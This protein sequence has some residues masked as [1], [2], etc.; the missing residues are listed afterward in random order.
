MANVMFWDTQS[1][2]RELKMVHLKAA[3][4]ATGAPT[5]DA[6]ASLG[7]ASIARTSAGLYR[8]TLTDKYTSLVAIHGMQLLATISQNVSFQ[9]KA[10]TVATTKL[11]DLWCLAAT[12]ADT[13]TLAATEVADGSTLYLT[14]LLKNTSV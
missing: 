14:L 3:I 9:I 13:T 12:D 5:L 1:R 10:E 7:V 6:T 2:Q 11:V 8:I 4:G